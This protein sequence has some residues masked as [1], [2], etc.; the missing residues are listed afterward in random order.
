MTLLVRIAVFKKIQYVK[1]S[2]VFISEKDQILN[3]I[4][5][6]RLL[7]REVS[8]KIAKVQEEVRPRIRCLKK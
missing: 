2:R 4:Q 1:F 5:T 7:V 3:A 8:K 6:R